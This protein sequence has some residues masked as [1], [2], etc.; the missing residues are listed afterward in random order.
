MTTELIHSNGKAN[1][2]ELETLIKNNFSVTVKDASDQ[3]HP[4]RFEIRGDF[5]YG[6]FAKFAIR[7][8]F[9]ESCVK[10]RMYLNKR[11]EKVHSWLDA[12]ESE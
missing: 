10:F 12:L 2:S 4:F 9:A 1:Q 8:G 11:P 7:K 3:V 5:D 6:E